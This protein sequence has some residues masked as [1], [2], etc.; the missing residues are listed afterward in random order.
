MLFWF[1]FGVGLLLVGTT[2]FGVRIS[3]LHN[4]NY[5]GLFQEPHCYDFNM[6]LMGVTMKVENLTWTWSLVCFTFMRMFSF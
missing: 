4:N 1:G 3:C 6:G 5:R 2:S